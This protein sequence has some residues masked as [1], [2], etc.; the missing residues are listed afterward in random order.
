M[1]IIRRER[2]ILVTCGSEPDKSEMNE[3]EQIKKK[4]TI[5]LTSFSTKKK[6]TV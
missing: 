2:Y 5:T 1:I 4:I 3:I 6:D